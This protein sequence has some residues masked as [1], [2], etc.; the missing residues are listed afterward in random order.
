MCRGNAHPARRTFATRDDPRCWIWFRAEERVAHL[1]VLPTKRPA[2]W[3]R[4]EA[5]HNA[6]LLLQH[7]R[8]QRH[9]WKWEAVAAMLRFMPSGAEPRMHAASRHLLHCGDHLRVLTWI[10]EGHRAHQC[11]KRNRSGLTGESR[12]DTPRVTRR[13]IGGTWEGFIVIGAIEGVEAE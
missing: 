2:V 10:T 8:T 9:L 13:L 3:S 6:E 7:L 12:Q 1:V 4:P 5:A 11:P